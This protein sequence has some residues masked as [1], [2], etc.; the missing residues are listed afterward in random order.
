MSTA[1]RAGLRIGFTYYSKA[2]LR[3]DNFSIPTTIQQPI[4][5]CIVENLVKRSYN[6]GI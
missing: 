1:I 2:A 4:V 6:S 3:T 5:I